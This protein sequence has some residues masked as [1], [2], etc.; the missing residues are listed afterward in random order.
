M[1]K[2]IFVLL[3]F[4]LVPMLVHAGDKTPWDEKLPFKHAT[5]T[6]ALSGL[7]KGTE[8]RYMTDNGMKTATYT[9]SSMK[10]MGITQKTET[11]KFEDPDWI[12]HYDLEEGVGSKQTNPKK[13]MIEEYNKLSKKEKEQV[14]K[15]SKDTSP[16]S[17][18]GGLKAKVEK[19]A[20][21]I[22]GFSCDKASMMGT[23]VYSIHDTTVPLLTES[24]MMGVKM[25]I[26]A[27]GIDRGKPAGKF[28]EHPKGI[29]AVYDP[30]ADELSRAMAA[31]VIEILKDPE[32]LKM[33]ET[34]NP[35]MQQEMKKD[36]MPPE[37]N[38][39][40]EQAKQLLKGLFGDQ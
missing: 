12:F 1:Y 32:G 19:N 21:K 33:P 10:V 27:I 8:I 38:K 22:L 4:M 31:Q 24:N 28:F 6:Y 3:I 29:T 5:I 13:Y 37:V 15:N 18:L 40:I 20:T 36:E 39:E 26:E 23:V 2:K 30:E 14:L 34:G 25:R 7:Q 9:S 11:I 17:L 16:G 35:V